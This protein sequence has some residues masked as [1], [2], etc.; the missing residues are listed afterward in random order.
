MLKR[1]IIEIP[2][3]EIPELFRK[4][5]EGDIEARDRLIYGHLKLGLMIVGYFMKFRSGIGQELVSEMLWTL[6]TSV[7]NIQKGK[8]D[9]NPN[10]TGYIRGR[11]SGALRNLVM[12]KAPTLIVKDYPS[13]KANDS[14]LE[15]EDILKQCKLNKTQQQV[16]ELR[17]SGM[18]DPEVGA[19]MGITKQAVH[20]I[21]LGIQARL[22]KFYGK[23]N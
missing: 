1:F 14:E 7:D 3:E 5:K 8:I 22:E 18:K 17:L 4:L 15:I 13:R 2:E 16:V 12:K 11:M 19:Q 6:T 21:R 23:S 20:Q 9:E 10:V